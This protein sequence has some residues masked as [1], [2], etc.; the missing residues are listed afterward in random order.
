MPRMK[1]NYTLTALI[2]IMMPQLTAAQSSEPLS[3]LFACEALTD[4]EAAL[5]CFRSETAKLRGTEVRSGV[6]A[7]PVGL[8]TQPRIAPQSPVQTIETQSPVQKADVTIPKTT[9]DDPE[10]FIP[11]NKDEAPKTRILTIKSTER[12]GRNRYRRFYL[13]NGEVW[14]QTE[15]AFMRLGKGNPDK[16]TIKTGSF[17]SYRARVNGK[18]PAFYVKREK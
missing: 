8:G 10:K 4:T 18:K 9:Q 13:E 14:K 7:A 2:L 15:Q 17:G 11:L 16:L 1:I 5:A 12:Y 6:T 3:G